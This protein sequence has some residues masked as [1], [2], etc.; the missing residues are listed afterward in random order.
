MSKQLRVLQIEDSESDAALIVRTLEKS[1]YDVQSKRVED[2]GEMRA[3]LAEQEWDI[4][5]ADYHLPGFDA[6]AA[7]GTLRQT[8]L[9]IPFIVVSGAIGEDLAVNLM[10]SG[11]HDYVMKSNLSRLAPAVE[12]EINEA[13]MRREREAA[14]QALRES[15]ERLALALNETQLGMFDIAPQTGKQVWCEYAKRHFGLSPEANVTTEIF[16]S[17]LHP[18]DRERLKAILEET[19][20]SDSGGHYAA[21]FRTVGIEDRIER[22][23]S[24]Q[25]RVFF[26][27]SGCPARFIG[28]TR[29][30]TGRKQMEEDLRLSEERFAKAFR[31]SP[32]GNELVRLADSIIADVNDAHLAMT[33]YARE[34]IIGR[35]SDE[36]RLFAEPKEHLHRRSREGDRVENVEL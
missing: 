25:G 22:W 29:D 2:A 1:G 14:E 17:A 8:G 36:V 11:A 30:I 19:F 13:Q 21:E 7:L 6:P 33:G 26:D 35:S 31:L 18:D 15:Q 20:R 3:S 27:S 23:I 4:I 28:V 16:E 10:K 34:E 5:I 24:S 32:V 12:R 9:D